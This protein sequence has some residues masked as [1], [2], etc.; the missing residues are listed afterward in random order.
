VC[1]FD[2]PIEW[3][4][5][6]RVHIGE[7]IP[8]LGQEGKAGEALGTYLRRLP[9]WASISEEAARE[10]QQLTPY[11]FRHRFSAEGHRRGLQPK[12]IAD[13]MGHTLEVHMSSYARFMT[14][15][16]ADA[17]EAVVSIAASSTQKGKRINEGHRSQVV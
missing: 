7:L 2:G 13:A 16:L 3:N 15:D 8:S 11:S 1:D 5:Q 6:G 17:F 14:R 12:Q 9:V 4:L 10:G